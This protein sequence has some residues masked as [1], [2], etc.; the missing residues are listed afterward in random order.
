[1]AVLTCF[2]V[3]QLGLDVVLVFLLLARARQCK[4]APPVGRRTSA[5]TPPQWYREFLILAEDVLALVEPVLDALESG[6]LAGPPAPA[7][8]ARAGRSAP[9]ASTEPH[10]EAFALLRAGAAPEEVARRGR[11][12]P[13]EVRLIRNLVAA[14]AELADPR[15]A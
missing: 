7:S 13:A 8:I 4:A 3:F 2:L 10:R 14:E 11:L 1:M 9:A 5:Q 6:R 15:K 12:L